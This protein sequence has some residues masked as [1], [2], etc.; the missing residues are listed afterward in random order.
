MGATPRDG[1]AW[2]LLVHV[3]NALPVHDAELEGQHPIPTV[4][5]VRVLR[6]IVRNLIR[7]IARAREKEVVNVLGENCPSYYPVLLG[8]GTGTLRSLL[9]LPTGNFAPWDM[10]ETTRALDRCEHEVRHFAARI[11]LLP[12]ELDDCRRRSNCR[13]CWP[14]LY[15]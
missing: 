13:T 7:V 6:A 9:N 11:N 12:Y 14:V 5:V 10:V 15:N 1:V 2:T 3:S 4:R 8:E